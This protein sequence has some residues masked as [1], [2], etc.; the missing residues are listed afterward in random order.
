MGRWLTQVGYAWRRHGPIGFFWLIGYNIAYH[1]SRRGRQAAVA[2]QMDPFDS[3]YGTDT[4]SY[5]DIR[6]LDV[7]ALPAA[8]YAGRYEPSNAELVRSALDRLEIDPE[9]FTF[10]DFG[11]GKGRALL[12]AASFPFKEVVGVEFSRE[13]HEIAKKNIEL[14]PSGIKRAGVLRSVHGDATVFELPKSDLVCYLYNPFGP[15]VI[16][17]VAEKLARHHKHHGNRIIIIYADPRHREVFERTGK[18]AVLDETSGALILTTVHK[19][20]DQVSTPGGGFAPA[21]PVGP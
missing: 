13:L 9:R 7:I 3:K 1:V 6:E 16:T 5:R 15:P 12:V 17:A 18:F 8:L 10:I 21:L 14:I 2:Q 4:A 11:S 19:S 20:E